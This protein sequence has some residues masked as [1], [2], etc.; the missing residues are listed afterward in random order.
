MKLL[1]VVCGQKTLGAYDHTPCPNLLQ[2]YNFVQFYP[3]IHFSV[4]RSEHGTD[5][6][7]EQTV[8]I[9]SSDCVAK[10]RVMAAR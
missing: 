3:D 7:R 6:C 9:V 2:F 4:G 8:A 5:E 1:V 10:P